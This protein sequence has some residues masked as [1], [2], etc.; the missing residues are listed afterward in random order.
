M[1]GLAFHNGRAAEPVTEEEVR[2]A[3]WVGEDWK[4]PDSEGLQ[5]GFVRRGWPVLAPIVTNIFKSS[6]SLGLYPTC[7]KASNAIPTHKPAK[8]DKSS[9]KAW[10]PVEQHAA[11]FAKPLER[12]MADRISFKAESRGVFDQDQYG[13]RPSHS[14]L[15]AASGFIHQARKHMDMGMIVSTLFFDLKGAY[16]NIS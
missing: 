8:K 2:A 11:V 9:P 15:Q 5:I 10:Q 1:E 14:T 16:N 3:I 13:G 12:L 6:V 7:L 4:A